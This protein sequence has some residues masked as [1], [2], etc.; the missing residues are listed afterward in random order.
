MGLSRFIRR[1]RWDRERVRELESYL[2][3]ETGENIARG[4][5]PEAAQQ[6]ARR[7]L[8]NPILIREEFYWMNSISFVETAWRDIRYGLRTMRHTPAFTTV[9]ILSLALGIGANTAVFSV[10]HAVLLRSLPYPEPQQL[11]RVV[12][13]DGLFGAV[14]IPQYEF[15]KAHASSLATAAGCRSGPTRN[16]IS[17]S[18]EIAVNTMLITA[19]FFRTLGIN[20]Q[21][22]R[23]FNSEETRVHGPQAAILTNGLWRRAFAADP[24]ILG[25]SITLEDN[26]YTV[27]G[28]LPSDF[29]F[30]GA[31]DVFIPLQPSGSLSDN[32]MNTEMIARLKPNRPLGQALREMPAVTAAFRRAHPDQARNY[33]GLTIL[34]FQDA[35]V[36]DVRLNLLLLFG[37]VGLLLL[38]ACSNLASLLLARLAVRQKEIAVRLSLGSSRG[39]LFQQF[40]IENL[41]LTLAGSAAGLLAAW[42]ALRGLVALIPFELPASAP[43][44]LDPPVLLFLFAVALAV[45]LLFSLIAFLNASHLTVH[46]ALK[47]GSRSSGGH[48]GRA[49]TV[50]VVGEVALS[51]SLVVGAGLLIQSLYR[52]QREPLGFQPQGLMTFNTPVAPRLQRS[53]DAWRQFHETVLQRLQTVPGVHAVAAANMLPFVSPS[54][55]P[56]ERLGHPENGIGGMEVRLVTPAYFEAMQIPIRSGRALTPSDTASTSPVILVNEAVTRAWWPRGGAI[57]DQ[58]VIG[59]FRGREVFKDTAREVVGVVADTKSLFLREQP[60]PTV[61]IPLA[62]AWTPGNLMWIVRA[63]LTPGL[64]A[65][66]RHAV[67]EIDPSQRIGRFQT[68]QAIVE[69]TTATSRF[70]AWLFGIFGALALALTAIGVYGLLSFS[71]AR[72]TNEIGIRMALGASRAGVLRMVLRQGLGLVLVGIATGLGAAFF[73]TRF[74]SSLLF[75][76]RASDPLS[77]VL[78]AGLLIL[79]GS[80]A[81]YF[82]ARRATRV[83]PMVALRWE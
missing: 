49:R 41:L 7:K 48:S 64:A 60:R 17:G 3:I 81:S 30:P 68:L 33:R 5:S 1:R 45:G 62:Q 43:I 73:L 34:R 6:A 35:L 19:D 53:P 16:L 38:I 14:G 46:D 2:E 22:G 52:M 18:A 79:A 37:A 47:T 75:G 70:D 20:P 10:V 29:W 69:T 80:L 40:I 26:S 77:F 78:G 13:S 28:V 42:G 56:T 32:G 9:A 44:R 4:M 59:R 31:G 55:L 51:V 11:L 8:G 23:E 63:T 67:S 36:G 76:V 74:L 61:Y 65:D 82:P 21:L 54:N 57:G 66:L 72:R 27:V 39:R 50:L 15:W 12:Q 58:V 25:R 24:R 83:D 71:I